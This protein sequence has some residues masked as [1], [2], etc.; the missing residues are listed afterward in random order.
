[1]CACVST[2]YVR[3]DLILPPPLAPHPHPLPLDQS[4]ISYNLLLFLHRESLL[5]AIA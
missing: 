3:I 4:P 1:M 5:L 2:S